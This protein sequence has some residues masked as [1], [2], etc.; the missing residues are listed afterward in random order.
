M[1]M[2][3]RAAFTL[4]EM[5][6]VITIMGVLMSLLLAGVQSAREAA[7]RAQCTSNQRQLGL[8]VI[9]YDGAKKH[10]PGLLNAVADSNGNATLL[11]WAAVLLPYIGKMDTWEGITN[12]NG[13]VSVA[14]WRAG[15]PLLNSGLPL[16]GRTR[17]SILTCPDD[18]DATNTNPLLSYAANM[19]TYVVPPRPGWA[20]DLTSLYVRKAR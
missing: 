12:A 3:N 18:L 8:A 14:G 15:N 9:S 5:L 4:V 6:V 17:I 20:F 2:R 10:L 16:P 19:G 11:S 13:A 7:R 1:A